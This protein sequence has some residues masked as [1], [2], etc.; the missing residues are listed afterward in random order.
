MNADDRKFATAVLNRLC[1]GAQIDG[2]RFASV[3]Q[4]LITDYASG[5][6]PIKGH[7]FLNLASFWATFDEMPE[8]LPQS[9]DDF[10]EPGDA[11]QI[12]TIY[13]LRENRI[14]DVAL[15]TEVPH[16]LI[17][18]EN[19]QVLFVNGWHPVHECWQLGVAMGDPAERWL[20]VARPGGGIAVWAPSSFTG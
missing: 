9:E 20:V 7:V 13:R 12:S 4:V 5:Q 18:L 1:R 3:L 15:G 2:V 6:A 19:H 10:V 8:S 14:V 16:L 17:K 11:E